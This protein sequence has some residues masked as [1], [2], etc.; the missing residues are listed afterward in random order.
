M[1]CNVLR[2]FCRDLEGNKIQRYQIS[3]VQAGT[4]DKIKIQILL[5]DKH[6]QLLLPEP[7]IAKDSEPTTTYAWWNGRGVI[8]K[9]LVTSPDYV[10][11]VTGTAHFLPQ[12]KEK[13]TFSRYTLLFW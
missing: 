6:Y 10:P 8:L 1:F 2:I 13:H 3:S 11:I 12:N 7:E 5:Q 9:I 4:K